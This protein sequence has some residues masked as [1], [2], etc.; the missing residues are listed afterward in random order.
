[1]Q[2]DHIVL[3]SSSVK[4]SRKRWTLGSSPW[5]TAEQV[6]GCICSF[7]RIWGDKAPVSRLLVMPSNVG[8]F[9]FS[10]NNG[11]FQLHWVNK[12]CRK[13]ELLA[14]CSLSR[15]SSWF[16]KEPVNYSL[17]FTNLV[18]KVNWPTFHKH[19]LVWTDQRR[20]G[21]LRPPPPLNPQKLQNGDKP[22]PCFLPM[23]QQTGL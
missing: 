5:P 9:N 14:C 23:N 7:E 13:T 11:W 1:M 10:L 18:F 21:E 12:L 19:R 20:K 3:P 15:T 22:L 4:C 16:G 2:Q 17:N 6:R 8:L